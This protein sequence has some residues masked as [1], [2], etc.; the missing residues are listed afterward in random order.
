MSP[1]PNPGG[2]WQR[3]RAERALRRNAMAYVRSLQGEP[4]ETDVRFVA[5]HVTKGD[6]D[7][8]RWELRYARRALGLLTAERDALDDRTASAVAK[9][10]T[11]S[12]ET[13]VNIASEKRAVAQQQLSA[14]LYAY[15]I[16]LGNR[17]A[18]VPTAARLAR[19]F[20]T[21]GGAAPTADAEAMETLGASLTRYILDA[22]QRL[23][24]A[25]GTAELPEDIAPSQALGAPNAK[26]A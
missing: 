18:H 22:N 12:V 6:L 25:F 7:H 9:A 24:D 19:T 16:A 10:L 5:E 21:F 8:A 13:D 4:D 17:E 23:R 11:E 3:W 15:R 20:L 2:F 1:T 14:R 26:R